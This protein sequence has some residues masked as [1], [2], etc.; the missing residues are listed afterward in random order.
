MTSIR[1]DEVAELLWELKTAG[2]LA[3]CSEVAKR[4]GFR[5][6][7]GGKAVVSCI[8]LVRRDW[9]HLQWWRILQDDGLLEAESE[10]L[11]FLVSAGYE[12]EQKK[13]G[14]K[15]VVLLKKWEEQLM[16]WREDEEFE[17]EEA[18]AMDD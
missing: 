1:A 16:E 8:R 3:T 2:K 17:Y 4:A 9:P 12:V 6:G 5:S 15:R 10:Q 13:Q 11:Q 7:Q 18:E 14:K